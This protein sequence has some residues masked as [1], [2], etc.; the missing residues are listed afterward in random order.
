MPSDGAVSLERARAEDLIAIAALMN[1]AYRGGSGWTSEASYVAGERTRPDMLAADL[2]AAP[3]AHLLLARSEAGAP[4]GCVWIEPLDEGAW[5][6]GSLTVDPGLQNEGAG[7]RLLAAAEDAVRAQGG[8][9]I[10]MTVVNVRESLIAWYERRGYRLTGATEPFPYE[11][12]RFGIP[13]RDD[14]S[15]VVLEK[16][17]GR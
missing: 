15:F 6:L 13:L 14:L 8:E 17:L 5:Y 2:A 16:V 12:A 4:W 7:R 10:R 1:T 9:R 3:E 11:D